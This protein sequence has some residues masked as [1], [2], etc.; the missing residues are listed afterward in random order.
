MGGLSTTVGYILENEAYKYLPNLLKRDFG[1][2]LTSRIKR[3][4]I[5]DNKGE[6]IEVNIIADAYRNGKPILIVGESKSQLSKND[7]DTFI[8]RRI[9]SLEGIYSELFPVMVTHMTSQPD[10]EDYAA[11]KGIS[12]YFSYDFI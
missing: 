6:Q 8:K 2:E 7:I 9:K 3:K 10:A 4:Y 1:I 12:L 11:K 5:K